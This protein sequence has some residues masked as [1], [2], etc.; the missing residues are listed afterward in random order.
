MMTPPPR[1]V[2]TVTTSSRAAPWP[3]PWRYSPSA[4]AFESTSSAQGRPN[5][6]SSACRS[7]KLQSSGRFAFA[8]IVDRVGSRNPATDTPTPATDVVPS[9]RY[10][11]MSGW[12]AATIPFT[13]GSG[14]PRSVVL[15]VTRLRIRA[16]SATMPIFVRVPPMSMAP[17]TRIEP[18]VMSGT[19]ALAQALA[20]LHAANRAGDHAVHG[21]D[22]QPAGIAGRDGR[23]P[24]RGRL[25]IAAKDL[26]EER[27]QLLARWAVRHLVD[28]RHDL[29][30]IEH[31]HV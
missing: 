31:V 26:L 30:R 6:C 23:K 28:V 5:R 22:R 2:P 11:S 25:G 29:A 9:P 12:S 10:S 7:G 3:A 24:D 18:A 15:I 20:R 19:S 1:P 14:S 17:A 27:R 13:S 4:A 16:S 21:G 8:T